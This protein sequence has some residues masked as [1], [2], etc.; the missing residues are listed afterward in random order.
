MNIHHE[1]SALWDVLNEIAQSP[2]NA[3]VN[4]LLYQLALDYL[5]RVLFYQTPFGTGSLCG[6]ILKWESN[7][8]WGIY[9]LILIFG[10]FCQPIFEH[11]LACTSSH[12]V[13]LFNQFSLALFNL[14]DIVETRKCSPSPRSSLLCLQLIFSMGHEIQGASRGGLFDG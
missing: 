13:F 9:F 10:F 2:I 5:K 8:Y 11:P 7:R 1:L 14:L 12:L 4:W 6:V 3:E